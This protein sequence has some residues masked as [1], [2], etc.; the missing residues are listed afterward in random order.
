MFSH[1][2][3]PG[4]IHFI[5][6]ISSQ[7]VV[8]TLLKKQ[9]CENNKLKLKKKLLLKEFKLSFSWGDTSINRKDI[10]FTSKI[11]RKFNGFDVLTLKVGIYFTR[12]IGFL[13]NNFFLYFALV[14][15]SKSCSICLYEFHIQRQKN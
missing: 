2:N 4:F 12:E 8:F 1:K 14:K 7:A 5:K 13:S 15:V 6:V 10:R 9:K 3:P 11:N